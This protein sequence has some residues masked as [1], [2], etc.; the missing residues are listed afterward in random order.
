M[1]EDVISEQKKNYDLALEYMNLPQA[2]DDDFFEAAELFELAGDYKDAKQLAQ[3]CTK[4]GQA[5]RDRAKK[6]APKRTGKIIKAVFC[7]MLAALL[8]FGAYKGISGYSLYSKGM[9]LFSQGDFASAESSFASAGSFP[10]CKRMVV[11]CRYENA[12][13]LLEKGGAEDLAQ[14]EKLFKK[15]GDYQES[16]SL[17]KETRYG[18]AALKQ[19]IEDYEAAYKLYDK[20]GGYEDSKTLKA[21]TARLWFSHCKS[22]MESGDYENAYKQLGKLNKHKNVSSEL[23]RA[24]YAYAKQLL[25]EQDYEKAHSLF[26]RAGFYKDSEELALEALYLQ[27]NHLFDKGELTKAQKLYKKLPGYKDSDERL[28]RVST[29]VAA[30]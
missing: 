29:M 13:S 5:L 1:S 26:N 27:A 21:N 17:L 7:L 19:E 15:L 11:S 4:K 22:L 24:G 10:R 30:K 18:L 9:K 2:I 6:P 28:Q 12:R 25:K 8:G 20:L 23:Q 16:S 14:A 3:E